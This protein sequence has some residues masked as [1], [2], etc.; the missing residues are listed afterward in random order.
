MNLKLQKLGSTAL[1]TVVARARASQDQNESFCD[2][3]AEKVMEKLTPEQIRSV[4]TGTVN[5]GVL[6]RELVFDDAITKLL[7]DRP[8]AVAVNIG[9][10]LDSRPFRL[11]TLAS[12]WYDYDLPDVIAVRRSIYAEDAKHHFVAADVLQPD[13]IDLLP[14]YV[15]LF[16]A[17]GVLMYFKAAE[18]NQ[19]FERLARHSPGAAI[20]FDTA[21][22]F[23]ARHAHRIVRGIKK[24]ML[25]GWG[26]RYDARP[27]Q[28]EAMFPVLSDVK[29]T[30]YGDSGLALRLHGSQKLLFCIARPLFSDSLFVMARLRRSAFE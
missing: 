19:L 3:W 4:E 18:L 15:D 24:G 13:F 12:Q 9:T 2:P 21:A 26:F 29:V 6:V 17:C 10:G 5:A 28:V 14:A 25:G 8:Q 27:E 16:Y 7:L 11:S 30:N 1:I 23:F 20:L 22:P